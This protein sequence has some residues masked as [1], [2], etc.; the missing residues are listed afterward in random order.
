MMVSLG[1]KGEADE[2]CH[3]AVARGKKKG[4]THS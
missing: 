1:G 2:G 3:G 4:S